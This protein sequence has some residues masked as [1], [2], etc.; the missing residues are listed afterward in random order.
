MPQI[1]SS[2]NIAEISAKKTH[3]AP[4]R[5]VCPAEVLFDIPEIRKELFRSFSLPGGRKTSCGIQ[6]CC[7]RCPAIDSRKVPDTSRCEFL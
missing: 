6:K 1:I 4:N 5:F 3:P 2:D 7:G